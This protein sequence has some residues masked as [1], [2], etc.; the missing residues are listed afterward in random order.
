MTPF[1]MSTFLPPL[2]LWYSAA[3][4]SCDFGHRAFDASGAR[5]RL[6]GD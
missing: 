4:L 6:T 3:R 2:S 5:G 1:P